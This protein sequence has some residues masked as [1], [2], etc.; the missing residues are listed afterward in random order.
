MLWGRS[1]F[2]SLV[3]RRGVPR[4][5]ITVDGALAVPEDHLRAPIAGSAKIHAWIA[6]LASFFGFVASYLY[7]G[8]AESFQDPWSLKM[9]MHMAGWHLL[10]TLTLFPA[11]FWGQRLGIRVVQGVSLGFFFIHLGIAVANMWPQGGPSDG[12]WIAV[13][14]ALS[15][16][17]FLAATVYGQK[18]HRD[19]NPLTA[20]SAQ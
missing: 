3:E 15:G 9:A 16:L 5:E 20:L 1:V 8:R 13:L 2:A 4:I 6:L 17:F 14:N 11:S 18:A 12:P 7:L 19:M 10:L